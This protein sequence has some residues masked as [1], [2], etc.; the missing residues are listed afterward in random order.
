[1]DELK[2]IPEAI[3]VATQSIVANA[4]RLGLTW[5]MS[6]ATTASSTTADIAI[7]LDNDT[8]P[9]DAISMIGSLSADT[10]VYVIQVPPGG[11]YIVGFVGTSPPLGFLDANFSDGGNI[12]ISNSA[13]EVAVTSATWDVEPLFTFVNGRMYQITVTAGIEVT[14]AATLSNV[15]VRKG[16]QTITGTVLGLWEVMRPIAGFGD[17]GAAMITY[18]KNTSGADVS[19]KLSLS[20]QRNT[21][22]PSGE[23]RLIGNAA[24]GRICT[25]A[26][27]DIGTVAKLTGL[28][29]ASVSV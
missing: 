4:K 16:A 10:R 13:T 7:V 1:M 23:V 5:T 8:E 2:I 24:G 15:R 22:T 19:T 29:A 6:M 18:A 20:I 21:A 27:Q 14:S 26:V 12:A 11:N 9:I 28:A 17:N 3:G 25:V